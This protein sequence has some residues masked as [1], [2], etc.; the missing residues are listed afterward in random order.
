MNEALVLVSACI[1]GGVLGAIFFGGLWWTV[2]MG[3]TSKQPALW[4]FGSLLVRMSIALTGFYAISGSRWDRMTACLAG[5]LL[6]RMAIMRITAAFAGDASRH[7][8]E[9]N[10]AP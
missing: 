9:A 1:A 10:H 3:I 7:H 8:T 5:F 6:A 2:R 4:F